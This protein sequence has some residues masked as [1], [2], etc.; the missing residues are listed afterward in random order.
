[1][2]KP[3]P[4]VT[5]AILCE[6]V[7]QEKDESIS[8]MR[9]ADRVQYRL[10]GAP[11]GV[12][13]MVAIQGL[14]SIKSGPVTGDHTVRLV[15]ERPNGDR[16]EA[17]TQPVKLLG[18]DHGQNIILNIGLGV[19]MDGVYW[20]DVEFDDQLLTRIPITITQLEAPGQNAPAKGQP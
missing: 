6:K 7:L 10:E 12:K 3:L 11:K 18:K 20:F 17:H 8:L 15:I 14:V 4:Y 19:E 2:D 9:I 16:K 1:M 5:A 13:P